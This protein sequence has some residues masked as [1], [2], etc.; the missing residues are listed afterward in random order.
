MSP[1]SGVTYVSGRAL[2][3]SECLGNTPSGAFR[4]V[5]APETGIAAPL[6]KPAFLSVYAN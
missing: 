3:S 4:R 5:C 1:V 6:F 2:R